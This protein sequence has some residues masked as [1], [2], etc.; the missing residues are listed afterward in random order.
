MGIKPLSKR[1]K[2]KRLKKKKI[3]P[4]ERKKIL[5]E[6]NE[7]GLKE[8][9][10]I[11]PYVKNKKFDKPFLNIPIVE[12]ECIVPELEKRRIQ[13]KQYTNGKIKDE[14]LKKLAKEEKKGLLEEG[15]SQEQI[16][17]LG[18]GKVPNGWGV[19]HKLP[20]FCGG[21]NKHENLFL[22]PD[23][24][25]GLIHKKIIDKQVQKLQTG[26][27]K[28]VALPYPKGSFYTKN[29]E[30]KP[31]EYQPKLGI[32]EKTLQNLAIERKGASR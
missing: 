29:K 22:I 6:L 20:L 26:D 3:S 21:E 1:D 18:D 23:K 17:L 28:V 25:H 11:I 15:L 14:F 30:M 7:Y 8:E 13:R 10:N 4:E 27:A 24:E 19:H 32:K 5:A 2:K 12:V 31:M 9:P 16:N